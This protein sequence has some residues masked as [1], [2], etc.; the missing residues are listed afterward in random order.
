MDCE[1]LVIVQALLKNMIL[2]QSVIVA[3]LEFS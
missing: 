3:I 1:I 2:N